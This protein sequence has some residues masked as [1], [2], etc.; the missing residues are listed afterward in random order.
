MSL[1]SEI[2]AHKESE[3]QRAAYHR[4]NSAELRHQGQLA[5]AR[6]QL[7]IEVSFNARR[8]KTIETVEPF[9]EMVR[10]KLRTLAQQTW[11]DNF[12]ESLDIMPPIKINFDVYKRDGI[13]DRLLGQKVEK[14]GD[15]Q[16]PTENE[17]IFDKDNLHRILLLGPDI[18]A[19]WVVTGQ[20][21]KRFLDKFVKVQPRIPKSGHYFLMD[22]C[23]YNGALYF[24]IPPRP[25]YLTEAM[26][27][28]YD[29]AADAQFPKSSSISHNSLMRHR[30]L[31]SHENKNKGPKVT[32]DI[33]ESQLDVLFSEFKMGP[34]DPML[35]QFDPI[36]IAKNPP[37]IGGP[38]P[39]ERIISVRIAP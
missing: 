4:A 15:E 29:M 28:A 7:A 24:R 10:S 21:K 26:V 30:R 14:F 37:F 20:R 17:F 38:A 31:E 36:S 33:D 11:G 19:R 23:S 39:P 13:N 6:R 8:Q 35:R 18:L 3:A 12:F 25:E 34:H 27:R 1:E 22:L 5:E 9:R 2:K 16:Y 32:L